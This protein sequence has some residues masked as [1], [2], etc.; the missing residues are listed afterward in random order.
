MQRVTISLD[1]VLAREF[2][3]YAKTRGYQNRSEAVRDLVREAVGEQRTQSAPGAACVA[4]LSYV[5][6]HHERS[7][8]KRLT[9]MQHAHHDLVISATHVHLDHDNCIETLILKGTVETVQAFANELQAERGV[10]FGSLNLIAV[11][12][13]DHHGPGRTHRHEGHIH[14]SPLR[15]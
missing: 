13:H 8:A 14:L 3:R 6:N 12:A 4:N 15:G 5:Y 9:S 10:R 11:D 1:A 7:M 2:D